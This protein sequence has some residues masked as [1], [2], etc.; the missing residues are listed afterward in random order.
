[1][2]IQSKAYTFIT[3]CL[4][5]LLGVNTLVSCSDEDTPMAKAVLASANLLN[6]DGTSTSEKLITVYSDATWTVDAPDWVR[7]EP[8]T[9]SGTTDVTVSVDDNLRDGTLDNPRKA[10]IVFHG[11]TIASRAEVVI[12]QNGD[13]YRD[14]TN[15]TV[16]QLDTLAN[17]A[18]VSVSKAIVMTATEDGFIATDATSNGSYVWMQSTTPVS[19]GNVV[20]IKGTKLTDAQQLSY[21]ACDEVTIKAPG[22][23]PATPQATDITQQI[24]S[25]KAD[26]RTYISATGVLNGNALGIEGATYTLSLI[27]TPAHIDLASLNGHKLK[28][29]GYYA[30]TA[31][32]IIKLMLGQVTDLGVDEV[33]Y[34]SEDF[35]WLSP[36]VE[37]SGAGRQ[38]DDGKTGTPAATAPQIYNEANLIDGQRAIDALEARG[39]S[40][41]LTPTAAG[42]VYLQKN[43]LKF[44]KTSYQGGINLPA[45]KEVPQGE[46]GTLTFDWAPMVGGTHKFDP[47]SVTVTVTN[48]DETM[49]YGSF[50]HSFVDVES[51]LEWLHVEIKDIDI[52]NNTRINIKGESTSKYPRWFL[53]NLKLVKAR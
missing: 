49:T 4:I 50:T 14:C 51:D 26:T 46:K 15:Y 47:V 34:Y 7:V 53:D 19:V 11:T 37:Q 1:M 40:F 25:Y 10:S 30:G 48:G 31:A 3:L 29:E 12:N 41:E 23:P 22:I 8:A 2:N 44:G 43:Y 42:Q 20:A 21:V 52:N 17:E 5:L 16:A 32:P 36:W 28:V 6:F 27:S 33:I 38:V 13:K 24:D 45:L 9:G 39:Y 18:V 35:E